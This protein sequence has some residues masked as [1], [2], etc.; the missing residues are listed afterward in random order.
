MFIFQS[1]VIK[2]LYNYALT[3]DSKELRAYSTILVHSAM[4]PE[5]AHTYRT[6]IFRLIGDSLSRLNVLYVSQIHFF[7]KLLFDLGPNGE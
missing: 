4:T 1:D 7:S 6:E 5:T 2:E 3:S